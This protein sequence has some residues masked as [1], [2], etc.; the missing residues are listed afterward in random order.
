MAKIKTAK[1]KTAAPPVVD[2]K[3]IDKAAERNRV[4]RLCPI[5]EN[6]ETW[7]EDEPPA[8]VFHPESEAPEKNQNLFRL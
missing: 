2:Q 4:N 8:S 1:G 3:Q 5:C 7:F 6:L